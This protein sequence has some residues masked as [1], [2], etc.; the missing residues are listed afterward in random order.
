[1]VTPNTAAAVATTVKT[2]SP[3]AVTP[4]ANE[5]LRVLLLCGGQ[6]EEHEVSLSSAKSVIVAL[7]QAQLS[8]TPLVISREGKWLP[9]S[10]APA[11]LASGS[12]RSGGDLVLHH[13][14][15]A[16]AFDVVFPLL[17]GP[18]GE[19]GTVQG[20]LTL[21]KLPFVGSGVLGS[22]VCMDK[23]MTKNVLAAHGIP[24]VTYKLVLR[25]QYSKDPEACIEELLQLMF[26]MF[27]KPTNLGS[28]VGISKAKDLETL[29]AALELA[30]SYDRRV[31]V[32]ASA[33]YKPRE[34]EVGILGNDELIVSPVG[35][36]TFDTEFYDY[37]TK[38]VEGRAEMHIP[39]NVPA[40]V[41]ERVQQLAKQAFIALDCAGLA[42][43]DFFYIQETDQV[44]LNEVNTMPGFTKTSMYPSL[45]GQAGW[46]YDALVRRLVELALESR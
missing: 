1:M 34:L 35:E 42:R 6:S 29:K 8:V 26:P 37:E 27:V 43:I 36:L 12:V 23:V 2:T 22:A 30:F 21:A 39:A 10:E 32:E 25:N 40:S 31:I 41:S 33:S 5:P 44:L 45:M 14:A 11:A 3:N 7:E 9:P 13:A 24:Q 15:S 20:M 17:H 4:G 46:S 19:D 28:S 16:E 38:Y 18:M